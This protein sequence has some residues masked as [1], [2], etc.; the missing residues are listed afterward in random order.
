MTGAGRGRQLCFGLPGSAPGRAL[1]HDVGE[2]DAF[3]ARPF[4]AWLLWLALHREREFG[5]FHFWVSLSNTIISAVSQI[6]GR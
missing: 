3:D 4:L 2:I 1:S 6:S 5:S